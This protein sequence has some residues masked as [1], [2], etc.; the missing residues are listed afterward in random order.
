MR[1]LYLLQGLW[2]ILLLLGGGIAAAQSLNFTIKGQVLDAAEA[3]LIGVTVLIPSLEVGTVSDYDGKYELSAR[4]EAGTYVVEYSYLGY[5]SVKETIDVQKDGQVFTLNPSL[6]E[7]ALRM[8]EVVVVGS[9]VTTS[10]R[11]LGNAVNSVDGADLTKASPQSVFNSL[12]GRIPGVQIVQNSGDPAGGFSI[13][14]RGSSSILGNS[15]PLYVVDGV[16][17]SNS[18]TNVT[19][20]NVNAGAAQPGTNRLVDINPNDIESMDVLNGA[21]AAAIYGSQAANGVVIITTKKGSSGAPR[22]SFSTSMNVNELRKRVPI[23]LTPLQFGSAE[24]RLW[25]I[26]GTD[27]NTGRLTV[28]RNFSTTTVP[29]TRYDYQ[30]QIFQTGMGTDQHLGVRGGT[31]TSNYY[32]SLSHT[33]N[34]GIIRNTDFR[35]LGAR[36]NFNQTVSDWMSF[37]IGMN[38]INT[39]SNEKPDG[40]VFWSPINAINITNNIWD[41]T[42]R[43]ALGN[44]QSVEPTRVNPLSVIEDFDITQEVNRL[45]SNV[46]VSLF[47]LA[48]LNITYIGGV[49]TYN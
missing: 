5:T 10:R 1:K 18:T 33:F 7:D 38:Y 17:V 27:P 14:A 13:R 46:K 40:N 37:S 4:A 21:A 12:Q 44:L 26:A 48:G 39:F 9:S 28:G 19:N 8:D 30:D 32:A 2:L 49:D 43:D 42:Q 25:P 20:R 41:I 34:E 6:E 35:R 23:N 16:I 29:V 45:I 11:A 47:P 31:S 15:D 24:Q 3:P 22:F 36:L